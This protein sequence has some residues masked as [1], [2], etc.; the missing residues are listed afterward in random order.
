M[1]TILLV[2]SLEALLGQ[3][4]FTALD[5]RTLKTDDLRGRVVLV[6]VWATWCAPCLAEMPTLKRLDTLH[7]DAL[8]IVGVNVDSMPRRDLR[9]WLVR[10]D[11]TWPQLF[12]GRGLRGPL[13]TQLKIEFLPRSF[14]FDPAGRLVAT[15]LRGEA[16][17]RAVALEVTKARTWPPSSVS[18]RSE[19]PPR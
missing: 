8:R 17:V 18:P 1:G 5:G 15:D 13:A 3:G 6:D 9:Q 10:R 14:L 16:L 4:P 7:G 2:L 19:R 11:I 12:D